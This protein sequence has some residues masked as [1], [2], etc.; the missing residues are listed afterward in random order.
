[1]QLRLARFLHV[2]TGRELVTY[3]SD[4]ALF[5]EFFL[6]SRIV[7]LHRFIVKSGVRKHKYYRRGH[8]YWKQ[9]VVAVRDQAADF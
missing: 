4:A 7:S 1:M 8:S 2:S 3:F 5:F 9:N 6:L